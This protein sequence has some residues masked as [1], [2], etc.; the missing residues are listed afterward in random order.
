[1][2]VDVGMAVGTGVEVGSAVDVTD[3][4][5]VKVLV[6]IIGGVRVG[7]AEASTVGVAAGNTATGVAVGADA[8]AANS[9]MLKHTTLALIEN[10][11][12]ILSNL[13]LD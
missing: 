3:A 1:M 6:G 8:H 2:G 5:G 12:F 9:K 11:G 7:V 4:V 13:V 10:G